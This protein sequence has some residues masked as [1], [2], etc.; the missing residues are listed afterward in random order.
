MGALA[1]VILGLGMTAEF[2]IG[3]AVIA[4]APSVLQEIEGFVLLGFGLLTLAVLHSA[5]SVIAAMKIQP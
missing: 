1:G 3:A 5:R 4:S 2:C